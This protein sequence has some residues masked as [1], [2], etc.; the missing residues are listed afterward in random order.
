MPPA[1]GLGVCLSAG[2]CVRA[3]VC[4]C[5]CS[6]VQKLKK[7]RNWCNFWVNW[8]DKMLISWQAGKQS[9]DLTDV[10]YQHE[11]NKGLKVDSYWHAATKDQWTTSWTSGWVLES[12]VT[13]TSMQ[14][15]CTKR[16][17]HALEDTFSLQVYGYFGGRKF[18]I[19]PTNQLGPYEKSYLPFCW[20]KGHKKY[21]PE[22]F[23]RFLSN[24]W[25]FHYEILQ[26]Y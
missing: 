25:E 11:E 22:D 2:A 21:P 13:S 5:V 14:R 1:S 8:Q 15:P 23:W 6:S 17:N 26:V 10:S 20:N 7:I 24:G 19:R 3:R 9:L 12:V 18:S 16:L 4:T